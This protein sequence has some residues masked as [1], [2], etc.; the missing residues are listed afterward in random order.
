[1]KLLITI[2]L[3]LIKVAHSENSIFV[4]EIVIHTAFHF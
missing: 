4:V 1:M 2:L 3:W